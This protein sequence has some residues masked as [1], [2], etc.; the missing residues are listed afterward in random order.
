MFYL[1]TLIVL[2]LFQEKGY[3]Q[4]FDSPTNQIFCIMENR[5]LEAFGKSVEYSFWEKYDD[6]HTIIRLATDWGTTEEETQALIGL[7]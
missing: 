5:R 2:E 4:C 6:S 1:A 7:L 3:Q